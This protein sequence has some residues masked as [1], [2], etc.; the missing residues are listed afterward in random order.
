M[1]PFVDLHPFDIDVEAG[2]DP[3][4]SDQYPAAVMADPEIDEGAA[5][6]IKLT[7]LRIVRRCHDEPTRRDAETILRVVRHY[8]G[9]PEGGGA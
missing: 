2:G 9:E 3:A 1:S 8:L 7:A 5:T 6:I 4:P